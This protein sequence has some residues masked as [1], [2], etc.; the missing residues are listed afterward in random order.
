MYA[1]VLICCKALKRQPIELALHVVEVNEGAIQNG[2][3]GAEFNVKIDVG[4]FDL[5]PPL[6][7]EPIEAAFVDAVVDFHAIGEEGFGLIP[8]IGAL[9]GDIDEWIVGGDNEYRDA[10]GLAADFLGPA[11]VIRFW[12]HDHHSASESKH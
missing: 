3:A 2:F 9:D 7:D 8:Q 1:S 6:F 10:I 5:G 11:I 12:L 4:S